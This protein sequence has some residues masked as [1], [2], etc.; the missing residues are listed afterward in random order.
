MNRLRP[1]M[2]WCRSLPE[3]TMMNRNGTEKTMGMAV[4]HTTTQES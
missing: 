1:L 2:N 3:W 4:I